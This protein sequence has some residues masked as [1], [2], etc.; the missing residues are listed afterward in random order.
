MNPKSLIHEPELDMNRDGR[1]PVRVK[2]RSR[3]FAAALRRLAPRW[4]ARRLGAPSIESPRRSLDRE[5]Q[6]FTEPWEE[7]PRL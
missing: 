6:H 1:R 4:L 5:R 2:K 3:A 7:N